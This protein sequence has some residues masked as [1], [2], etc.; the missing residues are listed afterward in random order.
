V[1]EA[2]KTAS[3]SHVRTI[4]STII[5]QAS[6]VPTEI[7]RYGCS[8]I[9]PRLTQAITHEALHHLFHQWKLSN[10]ISRAR[11][12]CTGVFTQVHGLP[13]EHTIK[14]MLAYNSQ[15]TVPA[16][17]IDPFWYYQRPPTDTDT[18]PILDILP[19]VEQEVENRL[20]LPPTV[21]RAS[22]RPRADHRDLTTRRNPS[23]WE[24]Q[25]AVQDG[26]QLSLQGS[27]QRSLQTAATGALSQVQIQVSGIPPGDPP[28]PPPPLR[29]RGG[30]RGRPRGSRS[31]GG[32]GRGGLSRSSEAQLQNRLQEAE[33]RLQELQ[34]Q[35][36]GIG[37]NDT[38][39]YNIPF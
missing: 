9:P 34:R 3:L 26:S 29:A 1:V 13:C 7:R 25:I 37:E 28:P 38:V 11:K 30:P 39:I 23:W 33:T 12:Q 21:V 31:R 18:P 27:S 14:S 8:I 32:R 35:I 4:R 24:A 20:I 22:G 15:W 36:Q 10:D 6:K 2:C 16:N 19:P 17:V 5:D